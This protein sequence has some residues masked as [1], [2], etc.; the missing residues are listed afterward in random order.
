MSDGGKGSSPRPFSVD[1]TTFGSNWDA[2][3]GKNKQKQNNLANANQPSDL[4]PNK[5]NA[6]G[7]LL[8]LDA[9]R[10]DTDASKS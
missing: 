9:H 2:I 8:D 6:H 3:F 5:W 1:Q 4:D 7:E 10:K